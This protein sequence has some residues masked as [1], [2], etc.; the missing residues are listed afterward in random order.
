MSNFLKLYF[1][2]YGNGGSFVVPLFSVNICWKIFALILYVTI[3]SERV[4]YWLWSTSISMHDSSNLF[5]VVDYLAY[6]W[7]LRCQT[8]KQRTWII[9]MMNLMMIV[10]TRKILNNIQPWPTP[11]TRLLPNPGTQSP[12]EIRYENKNEIVTKLNFIK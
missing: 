5:L 7:D 3:K 4:W 9:M 10:F 12:P 8:M 1:I 2:K 6:V 11:L